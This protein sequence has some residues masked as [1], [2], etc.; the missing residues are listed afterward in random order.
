MGTKAGA[1]AIR[2][3]VDSVLE[4]YELRDFSKKHIELAKA[5]KKWG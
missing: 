1:K 5:I 4:G 2:Q 3:A